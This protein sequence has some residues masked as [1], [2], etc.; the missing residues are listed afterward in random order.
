MC[1]LKKHLTVLSLI[2]FIANIAQAQTI[3]GV[4]LSKNKPVEGVLVYWKNYNS[5]FTKSDSVGQFTLLKPD[6]AFADTLMATMLGFEPKVAIVKPNQSKVVMDMESNTMLQDAQVGTVG[7]PKRI[8]ARNPRQITRFSEREFTKAACCNLSESFENISAVDVTTSDA[9]TGIRQIQMMGFSGTYIQTQIDNMPFTTGMISASGLTYIPGIFVKEMQ[10]SKG[11]G[12]VTNGYEGMTGSLNIEL[13]KPLHKERLIV[14]G[15]FNPMNGRP[16]FNLIHTAQVSEKWATTTSLHGS[17]VYAKQDVNKDGI[18]DFGNQQN[19]HLSNRWMFIHKKIEGNFGFRY[20]NYNQSMQSMPES[21]FPKW[22]SEHKDNRKE[23]FGM[24]GKVFKAEPLKSIGFRFNAYNHSLQN[25]FGSRVYHGD[26]NAI[27]ANLV[28]QSIVKS[29]FHVIQAGLSF[30]GNQT[31]DHFTDAYENL[32]L[33]RKEIVPGAFI[34]WTESSIKK[35]VL[36]GGIRLDHHSH[37]GL[38]FTP[39]LH[40][41]LELN[42]TTDL[43]FGGGR[44]QRTASP[45][46]DHQGLFS[47]NRRIRL[48][49]LIQN[50]FYGLQQEVSWNTG[51]SVSKKMKMFYRPATL[52]ADYYYTWFD[53]QLVADRDSKSEELSFY[54]LKDFGL[55]SFSH[56]ASVELDFSPM[57]RTDIRVAYRYIDS[58]SGFADG[59]NRFNP[60]ISP[61]RA[62][63]N[64]EYETKNGWSFDFTVNWQSPKRLPQGANLPESM[65]DLARYS[66]SYTAVMAQVMKKIKKK[67][68]IYAGGENLL[69]IRQNDLI[70]MAT[71]PQSPYFDPTMV[72]GPSLGAMFYTGFRYYIR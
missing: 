26:E 29:S 13:R 18:Q 11:V 23:I 31:K 24:L 1:S 71:D 54:N 4:V 48:P 66:P 28:Y 8:D 45:F 33:N 40:G 27:R 51:L 2:F 9:V 30:Y 38:I 55:K 22:A 10:L 58:R 53:N 12:S 42:K 65:K 7:N 49:N 39:R 68:E 5:L 21:T 70:R 63:F 20:L 19:I 14:N 46:A 69:N 60:M 57:R 64:A 72:W 52:S 6:S 44:G 59:I 67:W 37:F 34:E 32:H 50:G 41:K 62:F 47:S 15:Y 25:T 36:V 61:H 3:Q 16:E 17:G 35:L 56:S 43:R